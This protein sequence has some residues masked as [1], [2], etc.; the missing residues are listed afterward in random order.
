MEDHQIPLL[1]ERESESIR[2]ACY[3]VWKEFGGA[4]KEKVVDRALDIALGS[5]RFRVDPQKRFPIYFKGKKVGE[6]IPDKIID[7][8]I[9]LELKC[10]EYLTQEDK[11]QS[12]LYLKGTPYKLLLLVNFGAKKL[13]FKRLV[14]DTARN[15][16]R[17][18]SA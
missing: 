16:N 5:R 7:D 3:E 13:E 18:N 10:K 6:Y 8:I 17:R 2:D 9:I 4:F 11:R 12:W 14:Y 15:A 1:Y